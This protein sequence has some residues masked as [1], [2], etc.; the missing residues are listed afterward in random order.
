MP[1]SKISGRALTIISTIKLAVINTLAK[2]EP[3]ALVLLDSEQ[4]PEFVIKPGTSASLNKNGVS[5]NDA[6]VDGFACATISIPDGI[7]AAGKAAFVVEE[8]GPSLYKL[9]LVEE[10]AMTSYEALQTRLAGV[11]ENVEEV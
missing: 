8:F 3:Q 4:N 11:A 9:G 7:P 6:T 2:Y 1:K 10:Q 5:F